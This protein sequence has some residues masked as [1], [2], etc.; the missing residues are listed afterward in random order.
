MRKTNSPSLV[1]WHKTAGV[2]LATPAIAVVALLFVYPFVLSFISSLRSQEDV[3]T[4]ANY[5]EAFTLYGG[6]LVFTLWVCLASLAL[7]I[8]ISAMIGGF[9]RLGAYPVL[10]FIFKIPLFVPFVV[11]GHAMRVFLAPHGTLNSA[12]AVTGLFN[13]DML[14]SFAFTTLGLI[15]ALVWK[16]LGLALLL[17]LGGFRS[18]NEGMLEAAKGMG[19]GKLR[20]IWHF[21]VPM[22]KSSIGVMAVLTFTSMLGCFSIPAMLGNAGGQQMLMMDLYHQSVYQH[23][24]GLANAIGVLTYVASMGAAIYYLKGLSK[25]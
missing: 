8:G 17:V 16:N 15:A 3:W 24:Y 6:D 11:V 9:L 4:F 7:L 1:F 20:L 2:G 13:P 12:I 19:A 25:K 14:P 18:V 21:L 22:N 5:V 10:E 23:N